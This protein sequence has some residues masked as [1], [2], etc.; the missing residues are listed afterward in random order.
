MQTGQCSSANDNELAILQTSPQSRLAHNIPDIPAT[1]DIADEWSS[2]SASEIVQ[3]SPAINNVWAQLD[4]I[5]EE[6]SS[7]DDEAHAHLDEIANEWSSAEDRDGEKR[8]TRPPLDAL[9][10]EWESASE[11]NS[12]EKDITEKWSSESDD[13]KSLPSSQLTVTSQM[14]VSQSRIT[15]QPQTSFPDA[16]PAS[17]YDDRSITCSPPNSTLEVPG[18]GQDRHY[19]PKHFAFLQ[20]HMFEDEE[21]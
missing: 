13:N 9:A 6:W 2:E 4:H 20:E 11:K 15:I 19:R 1:S 3:F 14:A 12:T 21:D 7:A 10:D 8:G 5:A 16:W 17:N 18:A